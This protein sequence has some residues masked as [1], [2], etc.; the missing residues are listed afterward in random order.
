MVE[1]FYTYL[2]GPRTFWGGSGRTSIT[3]NF[4]GGNLMPSYSCMTPLFNFG[5]GGC[6]CNKTMNNLLGFMAL[7]QMINNLPFQ[8]SQKSQE[9]AG[10]SAQNLLSQNSQNLLNMQNMMDKL[11]FTSANGYSVAQNAD[12]SLLFTY[13][14]DGKTIVASSLPELMGKVNNTSTQSEQ[15]S[16][17]TSLEDSLAVHKPD[18]ADND[19]DD[20][21]VDNDADNAS[22]APA[23]EEDAATPTDSDTPTTPDK[24]KKKASHHHM[25]NL[26]GQKIGGK[27]LEWKGYNKINSNTDVGKYIKSNIKNGTTLDRLVNVMLPRATK[28]ER[29]KYKQ[30]IIN[31]NPNGIKDG[32]V[33]DVNKLDLPVYKTTSKATKITSSSKKI[34][35]VT[36]EK[37]TYYNNSKNSISKAS[38]SWTKNSD[39]DAIFR[40]DGNDYKLHG[41]G[42]YWDAFDYWD[43]TNQRSSY[44]NNSS[45]LIDK[46]TGKFLP[47]NE[48]LAK[49]KG[50]KLNGSGTLN[51]A[52]IVLEN[53]KV[54][55]KQGN[56]TL[57]LMDD[58]MLGNVKIK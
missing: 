38:G 20:D 48:I 40:I 46:K 21:K 7:N 45:I 32:K 34:G 15:A 3:N 53:G 18:K 29:A 19:N 52:T 10:G 14:K 58:V 44:Q 22:E 8:Y 51:G 57:G 37:I 5:F 39:T 54:V 2:H 50:F 25:P 17:N 11:G 1:S 42:D 16:D 28:E 26:A 9:G 13:N 47:N 6:G 24:A 36:G 31:G 35:I 55:L 49:R 41:V 27:E 12:G 33:A 43:I 56:K 30:W 4:Y 23:T